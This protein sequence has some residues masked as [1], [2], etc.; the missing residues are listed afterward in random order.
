[1]LDIFR[2]IGLLR[3]KPRVR[4][5]APAVRLTLE[6]LEGRDLPAPLA[7]TGLA[8]T[9]ISP[10][11][12]ALTWDAS[13]DPTVTGY[14]VYA[15]TTAGRP[16]HTVYTLVASNLTT[17]SDTLTG[18][19]RG[20]HTYVVTDLNSTG[21]SLYSY[22]AA[23]ET[24]TAPQ[25]N[26]PDYVQLSSGAEYYLPNGPITATA[27]LTT[28]VTPF[29]AGS[30]LTFSILSGPSTASVDPN[31]GLLTYTPDPS[32]SGPVSI[33]IDASN[34]LGDVT[35]TIP[36][37]VVAPNPTLA[38]PTL[39]LNTTSATYNGQ[40]QLTTATALGTDGVTPV[41]GTYEIAFNGRANW[42]PN[43]SPALTRCW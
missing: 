21:Q 39:S 5:A 30:P 24:W 31:T 42:P 11:A 25:S 36:F 12:I 33:T 28:Q 4:S 2:R 18:L 3:R 35:D 26:S 27:G 1:M 20:I 7:P 23:A 43:T 6:R 17:N 9:G 41:N 29:I 19:T 14:D 13:P 38:T 34:A 40:Y 8:A 16:A 10:A 15:V 22:A 32:E 37:N